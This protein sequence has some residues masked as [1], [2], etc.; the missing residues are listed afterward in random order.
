MKKNML[1]WAYT[2][3]WLT[4][5]FTPFS[6]IAHKAQDTTVSPAVNNQT[7]PVTV[8]PITKIPRV[9]KIQ[10]VYA[11]EEEQQNEKKN[12]RTTAFPDNTLRFTISNPDAFLR[13]KPT[14]NAKIVIYANG[15]ELN[16]ISNSWYRNITRLDINSGQIP[17]LGTTADIDVKLL[18]NDTTQAAW[19]FFYSGSRHFWSNYVDI[20]A[21]IGWEGMSSLER[22]PSL[23]AIRIVYYQQ[24]IFWGWLGL[25]LII[26]IFFLLVARKSDA[27]KERPDGPYSL[28]YTQLLFWTALII[29]GFI[30]TVVLTDITN[31][32]NTSILLLLGI[33][34]G[35]TG[36]ATAIDTSFNQNNLIVSDKRSKSFFYDILSDG[37]SYSIPR[38]QTFAWNL[39]LGLYF[40]VYTIVHKAMPVFSDTLLYLAGFS[41][42]SYLS[43][44][45]PENINAK[46]AAQLKLANPTNK[47][48]PGAT[49]SEK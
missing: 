7:L 15:V 37:D 43:A 42:V 21:S 10:T 11:S 2:L 3:I 24:W 34:I 33:S 27:L 41:S 48:D 31:S 18:R 8:A 6:G 19:N 46:N 45:L 1:Y 4:L 44:K 9:I 23:R 40:I 39:V 38:I 13:A 35:T 16:G 25:Y 14:D 47:K 29:G 30:Y 32:L 49:Q 22:A 17:A 26:L 12:R 36:S 20:D 5:L 28:S